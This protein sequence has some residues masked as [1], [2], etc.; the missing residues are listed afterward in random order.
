MTKTERRI[1]D[2]SL[3]LKKLGKNNLDYINRLTHVLLFVDQVPVQ[4]A[5]EKTR[6]GKKLSHKDPDID[7]QRRRINFL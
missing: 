7:T 6:L 1:K 4:F 5:G 2:F 3:G